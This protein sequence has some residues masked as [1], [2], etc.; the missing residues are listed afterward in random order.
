MKI[1]EDGK[2]SVYPKRCRCKC[3]KGLLEVEYDD[4]SSR[5]QEVFN[6]V[7]SKNEKDYLSPYYEYFECPIC[8]YEIDATN[9]K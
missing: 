1:I 6:K 3:C 8:G 5:H 2:G 9:G 7:T 4:V